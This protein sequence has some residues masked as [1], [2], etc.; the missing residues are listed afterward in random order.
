MP[1]EAGD[2]KRKTKKAKTPAKKRRWAAAANTLLERGYTKGS[3]IRI[4]NSIMKG[5]RR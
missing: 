5:K 3:A 2:A 1:W 4:A